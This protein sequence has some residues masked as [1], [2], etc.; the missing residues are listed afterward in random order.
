M[1]CAYHAC[2]IELIIYS[3][4]N[5]KVFRQYLKI[6]INYNQGNIIILFE[7]DLQ[8]LFKQTCNRVLEYMSFYVSIYK[9]SSVQSL[10]R[11]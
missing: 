2:S 11:K 1:W 6:N 5:V 10:K 4:S 8:L 3:L 9:S 7:T